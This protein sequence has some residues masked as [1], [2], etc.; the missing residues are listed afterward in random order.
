MYRLLPLFL[1]VACGE[2]LAPADFDPACVPQY[3][4]TF[5]NV[6]ENTLRVD[7]AVSGCHNGVAARAG[8]D[9]STIDG[10]Y[11]ELV[12][13]GLVI[14]GDPVNSL[15]TMRIFAK[16]QFVMPPGD[17]LADAEQCAVGQWIAAGADR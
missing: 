3:E 9:M 4:P 2:E 6:F 16:N 17:P 12:E 7:C 8:L 10:A 5:T 11:D 14:P 13:G 1:L 15:M